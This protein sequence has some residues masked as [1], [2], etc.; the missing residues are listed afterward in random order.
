MLNVCTKFYCN[1]TTGSSKKHHQLDQAN[2][3]K[4][5][6]QTDRQLDKAMPMLSLH[7][8][9]HITLRDICSAIFDTGKP[10]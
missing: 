5:D 9:A 8:P 10:I 2:T 1:P 6:G 4:C 3:L 7:M